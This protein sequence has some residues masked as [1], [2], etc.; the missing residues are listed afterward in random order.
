MCQSLLFLRKF[1]AFSSPPLFANSDL[2][3]KL[4]A[5]FEQRTKLRLKK[6]G[7]LYHQQRVEHISDVCPDW[8]TTRA[9][10]S[11]EVPSA[12]EKAAFCPEALL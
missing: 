3:L 2:T 8:C 12:S 7:D 10:A 5:T 6:M 4:F 9:R 11:C 1:L